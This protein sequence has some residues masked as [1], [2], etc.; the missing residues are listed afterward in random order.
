MG[1]ALDLPHFVYEVRESYNHD[2][3]AFRQEIR[4][5]YKSWF[6]ILD[7]NLNCLIDE[8][9]FLLGMESFNYNNEINDM[10]YFKAFEGVCCSFFGLDFPLS[11][12]LVS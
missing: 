12:V 6:P 10:K 11:H 5:A 1:V 3:E 2:K 9:E 8:H 7:T 4:A